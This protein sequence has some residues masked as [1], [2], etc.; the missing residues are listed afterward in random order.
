MPSIPMRLRKQTG[1]VYNADTMPDIVSELKA[2]T[3]AE[4][5]EG[6]T[7]YALDGCVPQTVIKPASVQEVRDALE[8]CHRLQAP[9]VVW[10]GGSHVGIGS[11]LQQYLW[12]MDMRGLA[13][14]KDYS[15]GDLVVTVEAGMT[16]SA[17]QSLL[18]PHHQWL[19]ID[20]PLPDVQTLGGVVASQGAGLSCQR[21]GLPREWLLAV[22]VVLA[23]GEGV[24]AGVGVVKNVAGYDLPRLFAGSWGTLGVLVELTFKVAPLPEVSLAV[25][26]DVADVARLFELQDALNHPLL[27]AEMLEVTYGREEGWRLYCGLAGFEEDVRWQ[28]DLLRERTHSEWAQIEA[29][30]VEWLRDR[31]LL[32]SAVCRCRCVVPP[33]QTADMLVWTHQRFPDANLQAHFGAG[34]VYVWW[35]ETVPDVQALRELRAQAHALEGFCVLEKAS[36]EIKR[37]VGVWD[38]VRGGVGVLRRLKEGF[39]PHGILAPGRFVEGL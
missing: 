33:A 28:F 20:V 10:G 38:A 13:S 7:A 1:F 21:Y 27:Q 39:D 12:A 32:A 9:G 29:D 35:E 37:E 19:P 14:L 4:E 23:S 36:A 6:C 24:K 2:V 34:I 31:Y 5:G 11:P 3:T 25:R 16:V 15:P 17:L 26:S 22:R 8:V 30:E 18:S